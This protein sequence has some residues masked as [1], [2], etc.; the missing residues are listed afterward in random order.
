MTQRTSKRCDAAADARAGCCDAQRFQINDSVSCPTAEEQANPRLLHTRNCLGGSPTALVT[1]EGWVVLLLFVI[2]FACYRVRAVDAR[3]SALLAC[4]EVLTCK[5]V[6]HC[7]SQH[8]GLLLLLPPT[9]AAPQSQRRGAPHARFAR[10][11][12]QGRRGRHQGSS[13]AGAAAQP[14]ARQGSQRVYA[15]HGQ[16]QRSQCLAVGRPDGRA[17]VSFRWILGSRGQQA[18][19][20]SPAHCTYMERVIAAHTN[21]GRSQGVRAA[22]IECCCSQSTTRA[23]C[24]GAR[25][26][27]A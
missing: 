15:R 1:G 21:D 25:R 11:S 9:A 4:S 13:C 7:S 19:P 17:G 3:W 24:L 6:T 22:C 23:G 5:Q 27:G 18:A 16:R 14:P 2:G 12:Q 26:A 8:A 20:C 10:R